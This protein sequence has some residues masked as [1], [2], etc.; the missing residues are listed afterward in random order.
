MQT[1][2]VMKACED[3]LMCFYWNLRRSNGCKIFNFQ[4]GATSE[5][6]VLFLNLDYEMMR[7]VE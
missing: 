5:I 6:I 7:D 3:I 2:Y 1:K 4:V